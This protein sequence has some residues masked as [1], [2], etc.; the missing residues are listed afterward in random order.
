MDALAAMLRVMEDAVSS[1][2]A[3]KALQAPSRAPAFSLPD[4][5]S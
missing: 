4:E 2:R 5:T 3:H 1:D